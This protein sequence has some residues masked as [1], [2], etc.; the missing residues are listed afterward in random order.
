MQL[1]KVLRILNQIKEEHG[2]RIQVSVAVDDF[3]E[4]QYS[5]HE[6]SEVGISGAYYADGDGFIGSNPE[7]YVVSFGLESP[8][9]KTYK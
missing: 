7:R 4:S 9:K 3:Q 5:Y 1:R 8:N 6:V 2:D